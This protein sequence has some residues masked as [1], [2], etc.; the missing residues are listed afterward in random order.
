MRN[1]F[2]V[3]LAM[4]FPGQLESLAKAIQLKKR[5]ARTDEPTWFH[6]GEFNIEQHFKQAPAHTLSVARRTARTPTAALIL[7]R[8]RFPLAA[9]RTAPAQFFGTPFILSG[10]AQ[11]PATLREKLH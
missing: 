11:S 1:E 10:Q 5:P 6:F 2:V 8:R 7:V 4:I 9:V 3:L